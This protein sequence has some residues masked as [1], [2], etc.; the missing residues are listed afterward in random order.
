MNMTKEQQRV[1]RFLESK[2]YVVIRECLWPLLWN[3]ETGTRVS[4]AFDGRQVEEGYENK[5]TNDD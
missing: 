5:G 2:G 1:V 3:Q 4:I